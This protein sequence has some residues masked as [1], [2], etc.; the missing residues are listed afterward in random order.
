MDRALAETKTKYTETDI[1]ERGFME[2]NKWAVVRVVDGAAASKENGTATTQATKKRSHPT[3]PNVY[4][5]WD[6]PLLPDVVTWGHTYTHV[7]VDNP[8]KSVNNE[9]TSTKNAAQ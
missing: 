9:N 3:K 7:V 5:V 4:P 6:L 1:I 8:P 2:A